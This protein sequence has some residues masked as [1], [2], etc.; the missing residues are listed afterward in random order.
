[1]QSLGKEL[2]SDEDG[3]R[4]AMQRKQKGKPESMEETVLPEALQCNYG[5]L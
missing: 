1:M 3:L 5:L 2:I 4:V